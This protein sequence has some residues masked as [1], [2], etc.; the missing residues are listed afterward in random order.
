MEVFGTP[1]LGM[2][3]FTG[4]LFCAKLVQIH[5]HS[6]PV[7]HCM[8]SGIHMVRVTVRQPVNTI[9]DPPMLCYRWNF[10]KWVRLANYIQQSPVTRKM[11]AAH[12]TCNRSTSFSGSLPSNKKH[13]SVAST[14]QS[15]TLL[16]SMHS[17]QAGQHQNPRGTAVRPRQ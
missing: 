15:Y 6:F 7:K 16:F 8:Q 3:L 14:V 9:I 17:K 2:L 4:L 13:I 11:L 5:P 12:S 10:T 1:K